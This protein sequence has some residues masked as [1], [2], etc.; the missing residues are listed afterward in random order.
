MGAWVERKHKSRDLDGVEMGPGL[1]WD[2]HIETWIGWYG[3]GME[4]RYYSPVEKWL[5]WRWDTHLGTSIAFN[6][7]DLDGGEM[8]PG[9]RRDANIMSQIEVRFNWDNEETWIWEPGW[10]WDGTWIE[11]RCWDGDRVTSW[12]L[13]GFEMML[14]W[15][16]DA[17]WWT[18]MEVRCYL[19][20]GEM[21][22]SWA[23]LR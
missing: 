12:N 11:V 20:V 4:L 6:L 1:N 14:G 3:T 18:W 13:Y 8:L 9:C 17:I 7:V 5:G 22:I 23:R 15:N 21:Q 2:A 19:D 10:C 16:K